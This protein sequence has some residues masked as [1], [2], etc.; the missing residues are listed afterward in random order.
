MPAAVA[1]S[2]ARALRAPDLQ[3]NSNAPLR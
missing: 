3:M 2:A 1:N